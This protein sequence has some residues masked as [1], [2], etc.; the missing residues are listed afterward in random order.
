[1]QFGGRYLFATP[2]QRVWEALND[3]EVLKAAIPGCRRIAWTGENALIVE[4]KVDLGFMEPTL[5][6]DL[7]LLNVVPAERYTLSGRGRG[8]LLAMAHA[9]ADI[10]LS[11]SGEGTELSFTA[12]GQADGSLVKMGKAMVGDRAQGLI[13]GFFERIG[14]A[15]GTRVTPLPRQA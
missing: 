3:P 14:A 1:M 10:V 7:E 5:T 4:I 9:A 2:R 11:D 12:Q 13:D 15:M 6:G 8:K